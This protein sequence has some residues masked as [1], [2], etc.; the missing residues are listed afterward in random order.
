MKDGGMEYGQ[1]YGSDGV[2]NVESARSKRTSHHRS[3]AK[4]SL[5]YASGVTGDKA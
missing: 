1:S 3:G 5:P 2:E 4:S